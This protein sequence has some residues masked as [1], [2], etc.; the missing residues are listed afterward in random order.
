MIQLYF[1]TMVTLIISVMVFLA[2][3]YGWKYIILLKTRNYVESKS[4]ITLIFIM[5]VTVVIILNIFFPI[6]PGPILLGEFFVLLSLTIFLIYLIIMLNNHKSKKNDSQDEESKKK[7]SG[8]MMD[9]THSLIETH[10][11]N[12]GFFISLVIL[13]HLLFP[14]GV[15][16]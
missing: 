11:R 5:L 4:I 16:L 15:L 7:S 2:D 13:L 9:K 12:I 1:I 6:P 3:Y 14:Q 10:K 8:D